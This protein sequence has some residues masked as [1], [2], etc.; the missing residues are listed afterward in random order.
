MPGSLLTIL[1][2]PY[3]RN[4]EAKVYQVFQRRMVRYWLFNL[5]VIGCG[6]AISQNV[7][8][9][10]WP[11]WRGPDGSGISTE[12]DL[13]I[14][15]SS[16]ENIHWRVKLNHFGNSTPII[17]NRQLF[18]TQANADQHRREVIA[19][20]RDSGKTLWKDGVHFDANE[21]THST[22]PYCSASPVTDGERVIAWF[23]S[24]GLHCW[25][26]T[27]K[28]LWENVDL[29]PQQHMW[30]FA[31]SPILY[32][33]LCI[34]NF[35][36][37]LHEFVVA[38]DKKT[39]R[40]KWRVNALSPLDENKLVTPGSGGAAE[41]HEVAV[42]APGKRADILRGSWATPLLV[43]TDDQDTLIISHPH[44]VTAYNPVNGEELWHCRGLG[45]LHYASPFYGEG[46]IVS[47]SGYHGG[48]LGVRP[49]GTGDV[50]DTQR[51][52]H[53]EK[54]PLWLG[55]GVIHEGRIYN[56]DMRGKG[57]CTDLMT[58][59][60]IWETRLAG[61]GDNPSTW[62]SAVLSGDKV[63]LLNQAGDTF[64]FRASPEFELLA[65]NSL[66]ETTNSSPA[67]SDGKLWIRTHNSLWC[68]GKKD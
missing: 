7:R 27:G 4:V 43:Q 53:V 57:I 41:G 55:C 18:L 31:A 33:D 5:L 51:L 17:W 9:E 58:G 48:G 21:P 49:G 44:R 14:H 24:A 6:Q 45:P 56:A 64:V 52:W 26:V 13:P 35:G 15:W 46:V 54:T 67:V 39:G 40:E 61:P 29:G 23:G 30:G 47:L 63:Y 10:N 22:N 59:E 8:A 2:R 32:G 62:S 20:D 12:T 16:S 25:N 42:D 36:P 3:T 28:K 66:G 34:L 65:T 50:T 38:V 1:I 11:A 68:I 19:L 37:G 60:I